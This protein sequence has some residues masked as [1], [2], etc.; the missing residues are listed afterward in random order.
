MRF[1]LSQNFVAS[2]R[3]SCKMV[4][5]VIWV[6]G[7]ICG[8]FCAAGADNLS[9]LMRACCHAGVSIVGLF[10][11]PFLPFLISAV[12]VYCHAPL[13]IL[14]TGLCK[15][16]L[17]G[18]C[19]CVVHSGF[20]QGGLLICFLLLFTDILTA[21][22]LFWF[23]MRYLQGLRKGIVRDSILALMWFFAVSA[24]DRAWIVPLLRDII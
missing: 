12:A 18:L 17:L 20:S 15:S 9:S 6:L 16:F 3:R 4:L 21:P 10:F 23:Q 5:A 22:A 1:F 13:I 14:L 7:L 8:S 24:V 19:I 2:S 11:V